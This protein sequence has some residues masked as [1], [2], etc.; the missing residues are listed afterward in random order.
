LKA[1]IVPIEK[2]EMVR[3]L[4]GRNYV[5]AAGDKLS[6]LKDRA[7]NKIN[8]FGNRVSNAADEAEHWTKVS[9]IV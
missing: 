6:E 7:G 8:R 2:R 4:Q 5:D 1:G 3:C 9:F